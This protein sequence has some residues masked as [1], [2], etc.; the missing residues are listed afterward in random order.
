M[1]RKV[2]RGKVEDPGRPDIGVGAESGRENEA[3]LEAR[4]D[5]GPELPALHRR[6]ATITIFVA[7]SVA[8][9]AA[10]GSRLSN[11]DV[12]RLH[13]AQTQIVR[14][15]NG[16]RPANSLHQAYCNIHCVLQSA[17][18]KPDIDGSLPCACS[19]PDAGAP[20]V[21]GADAAVE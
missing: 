8:A 16:E 17:D 13:N 21:P 20:S 12:D 1:Q 14:A 19:I 10:C 3:T 5:T 9:A 7:A 18:E 6:R 15:R 11:G 2:R 4:A